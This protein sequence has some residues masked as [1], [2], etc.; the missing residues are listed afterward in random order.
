MSNAA[1]VSEGHK[2]HIE[3]LVKSIRA[4]RSSLD[5]LAEKLR[6]PAIQSAFDK[7]DH[8]SWCLAVAGD[9]IVRIRLFIEQNFNFIETIGLIAVARYIH[10]LSIWLH[11]FKRDPRY[12]LVYFDQLL[13]TQRRYYQD[14][15]AQLKREIVLLGLFA[16]MESDNLASMLRKLKE[17]LDVSTLAPALKSVSQTV[18]M[19][20]SRRFAIYIEDAKTNGYSFQASLVETKAIPR[21]E[22]ALSNIARERKEFE[23]MVPRYIKDLIPKRWQWRLMAQRVGLVDEYDYI[24][25][26]SSKLLHATPASI[27]T[28]QKNLEYA[29]VRI[30][31]KYINVKVEEI[32]LLAEEYHL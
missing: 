10:E 19:L 4:R 21:V 20:A 5:A 11:L 32:M 6:T 13:E 29:E 26:F 12:G 28:D 3:E 24:Y 8:K 30:F 17:P 18:D 23:R 27:T 7:W 14:E 25:S 15:K 2:H 1:A 9:S 22:E 31:L 16:K